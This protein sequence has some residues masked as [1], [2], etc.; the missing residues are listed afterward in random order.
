MEV[1]AAVTAAMPGNYYDGGY[2][3][4]DKQLAGIFGD[5]E[6]LKG[7]YGFLTNNRDRLSFTQCVQAYSINPEA[8]VCKT[9]DEWHLETERRIRRGSKGIPVIDEAR[10]NRKTYL[11]DLKQ[12]YGYKEYRV[13]QN[14]ADNALLDA[15]RAQCLWINVR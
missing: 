12:T 4:A 8:T 10:P 5:K 9:Y 6:S 2:G 3:Y 13:R 15:I 1:S 14:I 11:F 7:F